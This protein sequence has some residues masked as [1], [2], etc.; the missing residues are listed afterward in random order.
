MK[1]LFATES[2][3]NKL[4]DMIFTCDIGPVHFLSARAAV[5]AAHI[6]VVAEVMNGTMLKAD[7]LHHGVVDTFGSLGASSRAW[8]YVPHSRRKRRTLA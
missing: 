6:S 4:V 2:I 7:V 3:G 5:W 8:S 1:G